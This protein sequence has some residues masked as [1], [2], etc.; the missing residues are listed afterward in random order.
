MDSVEL[1]VF[2]E[3]L[4]D[5]VAVEFPVV[6]MIAVDLLAVEMTAAE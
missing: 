4:M 1:P 3:R 2:V 6:E 5:M